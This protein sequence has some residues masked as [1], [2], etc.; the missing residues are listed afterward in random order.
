M[1]EVTERITSHPS[2]KW[3]CKQDPEASQEACS[4]DA[5][6]MLFLDPSYSEAEEYSMVEYF[7]LSSALSKYVGYPI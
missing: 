3:V 7:G 6:E 2:W 4:S 5:V 1:L